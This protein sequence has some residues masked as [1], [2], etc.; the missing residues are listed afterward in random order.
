MQKLPFS[1]EIEGQRDV[2]DGFTIH[3]SRRRRKIMNNRLKN[4][5]L[6]LIAEFLEFIEGFRRGEKVICVSAATQSTKWEGKESIQSIQ[7]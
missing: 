2:L 3:D 1:S 7:N 4:N 6:E 5:L